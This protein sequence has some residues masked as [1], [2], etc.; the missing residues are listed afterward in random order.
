MKI[1]EQDL[2]HGPALMQIV[3][4]ESFTALNRAD[5]ETY[6]YYLVNKDVRL[7]TKYATAKSGPW[8]FTFQPGDLAGIERDI[9]RKGAVHVVLTC[10]H[11][12]ICCLAIDEVRQLIDLKA[13]VQQWIKV[14]A[15]AGKQLRI[16]GSRSKKPILVAHNRFPNCIFED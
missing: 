11:H 3:E 4:H 7:R 13:G 2:Y 1:Q 12:T 5:D 9:A 15:P 6:G 14:E 10:G 16:T 8:S